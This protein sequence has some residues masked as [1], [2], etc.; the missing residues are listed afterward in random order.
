MI[1]KMPVASYDAMKS[2]LRTLLSEWGF[3]SPDELE[4]V[5]SFVEREAVH[6]AVQAQVAPIMKAATELS[7]AKCPRKK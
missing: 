7:Q 3:W 2:R 6:Y 4:K 5:A 1:A